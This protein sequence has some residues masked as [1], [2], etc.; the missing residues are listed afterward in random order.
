V[1]FGYSGEG[2]RAFAY[3]RFTFNEKKLELPNVVH[4]YMSAFTISLG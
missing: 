3:L 1:Y 4:F 2:E